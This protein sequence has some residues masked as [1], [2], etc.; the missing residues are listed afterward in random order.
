MRKQ[1][2]E[3]SANRDSNRRGTILVL[4]AVLSL[5]IFAMLSLA[6]DLGRVT[7][8]RSE[9]QNAVDSGALAA[10]LT[11]QQNPTAVDAAAA[12]A[13]E[14]VRKNRVGAAVQ[15][16]ENAIQVEVG[17]WDQTT[18]T[19]TQT[20][21]NPNAVRVFARQDNEDYSFARVLGYDTF[22]APASS[23]A[24][25]TNKALDIMM[26]LD[27]S[28]SMAYQGR[29]EA[30]RRSAP[31]FVDIIEGLGG[32]DQIGVMGLSA[33]PDTYDPQ[34]KGH[35]G[36]KYQSSLHPTA[37]HHVGVLEATLTTNYA[38]LRNN[39]LSSSNLI[40]GKYTGWTGTGAALGDS[41][42]YLINGSEARNTADNIVVLMSDGHAN[43]PSAS[44]PDYLRTMANYA[45]TNGVVVYT[46]SLGSSADISL[47]KE[48]AQITGGKHFDATGAGEEALTA[49]LTKAF[50]DVAADI[51]RTQLV[52]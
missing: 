1:I 33:N 17:T 48:V 22:G 3:R 12:K 14:F 50:Q 5:V 18:K 6:M 13:R 24:T 46:I 42:H 28:G 15:I 37:D 30:L 41:V 35:T 25:G 4:V 29:I 49:A 51:K 26:V 16:P 39:K 34:A 2:Q 43:R 44:G 38:D 47:M 27:L 20:T 52:K 19:F 45:K 36:V 11:L 40:A 7:V 10:Q 31:V 9:I 32:D 23:V 21:S 8:L